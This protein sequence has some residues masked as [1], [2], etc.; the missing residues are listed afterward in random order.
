MLKKLSFF[1]VILVCS[2][3]LLI[4]LISHRLVTSTS[5][6]YSPLQSIGRTIQSWKNLE[7]GVDKSDP[8]NLYDDSFQAEILQTITN[9]RKKIEIEM[10]GY[11]YPDGKFNISA[12]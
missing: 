10:T 11:N 3:F 5:F 9:Q 12:R 6:E 1:G 8:S 4:L 2:V 7:D